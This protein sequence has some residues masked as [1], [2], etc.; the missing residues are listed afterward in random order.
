MALESTVI[1][2]SILQKEV[3]GDSTAR[4]F[5]KGGAAA[6]LLLGNPLEPGTD[7]DTYL[8]INPSLPNFEELREKAIETCLSVLRR[9]FTPQLLEYG[10]ETDETLETLKRKG[11]CEPLRIVDPPNGDIYQIFVY[12][13]LRTHNGVSHP[14]TLITVK[15]FVKTNT[16]HTRPTPILDIIIPKREYP[17]I[18]FHWNT[19]RAVAIVVDGLMLPVMDPVSVYVDQ[20]YAA[21]KT[22]PNNA[23]RGK[24]VTRANAVLHMIKSKRL[25]TRK[26]YRKSKAANLATNRNVFN[27]ILDT[28][29]ANSV[30]S[31]P[32][33]PPSRSVSPMLNQTRRNNR[34]AGAAAGAPIYTDTLVYA[35]PARQNVYLRS[36]ADGKRDEIY[37]PYTGKL[38]LSIEYRPLGK[39]SDSLY[40][41]YINDKHVTIIHPFL[42]ESFDPISLQKRG[43]PPS[44]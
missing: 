6:Q 15:H 22:A 1:I 32:P 23:K 38:L 30:R 44:R 7:I 40:H 28:L 25:E 27:A 31:P 37:D 10:D 5:I 18:E 21:A 3:G 35:P 19:T 14:L 11:C 34:S 4:F 33:L 36:Y 24:R 12:S 42:G 43:P 41:V 20:A 16:R 9:T 8:L 29:P 17:L 39:Y 2:A 26:N 13:S